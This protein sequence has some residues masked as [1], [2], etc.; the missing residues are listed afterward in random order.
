MTLPRGL[1]A[2]HRE[3]G[4]LLRERLPADL[5]YHGPAHTLD[6]VLPAAI[7]LG[8]AEG[9]D[10]VGMRLLAAA[11]LFHD[12]GFAE[13]YDDN[14]ALGA[15]LAAERLP[16]HGFSPQEIERVGALILATAVRERDGRRLQVPGPDPLARILCDADLDNLGR[17]DF[18]EVSARLRREVAGRKGDPGDRAWTESQVAFLAGHEWFTASQR[19]R[20]GEGKIRNLAALRAELLG[21]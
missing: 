20:R 8:A 9:V 6:D 17:A 11:A 21:P 10:P 15:R 7:D 18:P 13:R 1:E 3:A 12:A 2:L 5:S 16:A 19:A 4:N 14:E